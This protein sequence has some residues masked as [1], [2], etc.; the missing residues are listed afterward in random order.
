MIRCLW[1]QAF[2]GLV[3]VLGFRR[4][5]VQK[6]DGLIDVVNGHDDGVPVNHPNDSAGI[7]VSCRGDGPGCGREYHRSGRGN[8]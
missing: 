6:T 8:C 2:C 3:R 4:I 7:G 5:D 1:A